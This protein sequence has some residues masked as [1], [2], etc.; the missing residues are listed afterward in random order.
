MASC[1]PMTCC[2][3][4]D[5]DAP[6]VSGAPIGLMVIVGAI[7]LDEDPDEAPDDA[8]GMTLPDGCVS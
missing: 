1:E 3:P 7:C 6:D 8:G 5:A 2:E 4:E